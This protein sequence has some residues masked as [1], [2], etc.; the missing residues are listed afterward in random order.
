M[1]I[2]LGLF[3][4]FLVGIPGIGVLVFVGMM[5]DRKLENKR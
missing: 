4:A 5:A 1:D 2:V 3:A